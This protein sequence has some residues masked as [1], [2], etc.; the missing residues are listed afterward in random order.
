MLW[1]KKM[2][3]FKNNNKKRLGFLKNNK[4]ACFLEKIK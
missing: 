3:F 4:N 1:I 2:S